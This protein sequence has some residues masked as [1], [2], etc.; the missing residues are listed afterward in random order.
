MGTVRPEAREQHPRMRGEQRRAL[1][2]E[3]AKK[4]F[5][6]RGY[7]EASIGAL[8]RASGVTEPILYKHF[9]SKKKLY[10][11]MLLEIEAQ[12]MQRFQDLVNHRAEQDL[13]DCLANLLL[14]YRTAAMADHESVH[15]LLRAG[16][17]SNDSETDRLNQAHIKKIFRL[18]HDLLTRAHAESLL[19]AHLDLTA[20][21]WGYLSLLFALQ[22]R[23]Q[24]QIF[25][26]YTEKTIREV[27][28]LWL[29]ALRSG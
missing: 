27:N 1:I 7:A 28:R 12:F 18:V 11:T 19:T 24:M 22:Y 15:V 21:T 8:A 5:A 17:T 20:A 14:D 29:Q 6:R 25:D 10:Q 13:L 16:L 9:G 2:L 26:Q 4:L 3:Q 23:G